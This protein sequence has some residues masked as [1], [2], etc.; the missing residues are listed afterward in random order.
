MI[1]SGIVPC[2]PIVKQNTVFQFHGISNHAV[3]THKGAVAYTL[4]QR[5]GLGLAM[6]APVYV[7]AKDMAANTVTVGPNESLFRRSLL[8]DN[9]NWIAIPQLTAPIRVTAKARSRMTEQPATVYPEANGIA[10]VEFDEPQ[11][12]ITPGQTVAGIVR[13]VEEYGVFVELAPNLAG[14]AEVRDC[15]REAVHGLVGRTAAV[16]IKSIIP[17]RM[18]IKL[19][20]IDAYR[21]DPVPTPKLTYFIDGERTAH[22]DRWVYSPARAAKRIESIF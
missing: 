16:F 20:L 19:V 6:G 4:G 13:S 22:I 7:C 14:L 12:A 15:D 17:E 10:R 21:S 9:W 2:C 5:K 11:R 8:A 18:K 1:K 3:G